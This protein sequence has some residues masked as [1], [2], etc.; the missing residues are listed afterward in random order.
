M[1]L[2][3]EGGLERESRACV[4]ISTQRVHAHARDVPFVCAIDVVAPRPYPRTVEQKVLSAVKW[5]VAPRCSSRK[6]VTP[7]TQAVEPTED[8]QA[9]QET[10]RTRMRVVSGS[11]ELV[12]ALLRAA[13]PE[14][15]TKARQAC[16]TPALQL[17]FCPT[18]L[19]RSDLFFLL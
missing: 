14:T 15:A 13:H 16:F 17:V 5:E 19:F 10:I 12:T 4:I 11:E 2:S 9:G 3:R 18:N 1:S 8:L 6:P 7:R